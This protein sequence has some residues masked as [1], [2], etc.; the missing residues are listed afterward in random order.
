M[1]GQLRI[2][3]II[4]YTVPVVRGIPTAAAGRS[5]LIVGSGYCLYGDAGMII[6][7]GGGVCLAGGGV[8]AAGGGG[9]GACFAQAE[10]AR[11]DHARLEANEEVFDGGN[12]DCENTQVKD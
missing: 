7:G 12:A 1:A 2:D 9:C 10:V 3:N 5:I 4:I 11:L 8:R 6:V